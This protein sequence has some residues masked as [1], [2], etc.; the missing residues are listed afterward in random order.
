MQGY[1][2]L[3]FEYPS[4]SFKKKKTTSYQCRLLEKKNLTRKRPINNRKS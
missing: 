1:I 2:H 3:N 4:E